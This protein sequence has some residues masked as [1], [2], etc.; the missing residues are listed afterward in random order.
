MTRYNERNPSGDRDGIPGFIRR[1]GPDRRRFFLE[2]GLG[3]YPEDGGPLLVLNRAWHRHNE[4]TTMNMGGGL[5]KKVM[6]RVAL[7]ALVVC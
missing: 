6:V 1:G 7:A 2:I 5:F 3:L 4:A